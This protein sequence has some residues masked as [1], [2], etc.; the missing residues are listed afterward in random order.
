MGYP[1][2]PKKRPGKKSESSLSKINDLIYKNYSSIKRQIDKN[3]KTGNIFENQ[4]RLDL[5]TIAEIARR[6]RQVNFYCVNELT[7]LLNKANLNEYSVTLRTLFQIFSQGEDLFMQ[8]Y[9]NYMKFFL[10]AKDSK[11]LANNKFK[12]RKMSVQETI[13]NMMISQINF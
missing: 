12:G 9:I 7:Y 13:E 4:D 11:S 5:S 6:C 8:N 1:I 10:Y 3:S 2:K